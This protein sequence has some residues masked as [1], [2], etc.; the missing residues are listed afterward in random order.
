M[1]ISIP[2]SHDLISV[3]Q[4]ALRHIENDRPRIRITCQVQDFLEDFRY[5]A[6]DIASR[7][8]RIAELV[9]VDIPDTIGACDAAGT[10]MGGAH[11]FVDDKGEM[12]PLLWRK[13][14][15]AS[16]RRRLVSFKNPTGDITT[17]TRKP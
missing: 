9:P 4:E 10:G 8:T 15:L 11:F 6:K 3:L 14:F 1:S 17:V 13:T 16:I 7:P 12:V 5:L 2:G